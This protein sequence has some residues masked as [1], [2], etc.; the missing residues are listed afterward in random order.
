MWFQA[1]ELTAQCSIPYQCTFVDSKGVASPYGLKVFAVNKQSVCP[2]GGGTCY[3]WVYE[4]IG[5]NSRI[6]QV[7]A[8]APDSCSEMSYLVSGGGQVIPPGQGDPTT[9]FGIWSG[10]E[11]VI[12]MAYSPGSAG[13][14]PNYN[15]FTSKEVPSRSTSMQLKSGNNIYYCK[16]IAGPNTPDFPNYVPTTVS[17]RQRI[18]DFDVCIE[19]MDAN[20]CPTKVSDC[21]GNFWQIVPMESITLNPNEGKFLK[22]AQGDSDPRCPSVTLIVAG[23]TCVKRC[24]QSG[25][26]YVGPTG[27]AP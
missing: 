13:V 24:Y 25:Y 7:T 5:D 27:C 4:L 8:L 26:C 14:P 18:A 9:Q 17:I 15:F 19:E 22:W 23:S 20:G 2:G 21:Q 10:Y 11:Y 12:R 6:N 3:Q 1:T 16:N